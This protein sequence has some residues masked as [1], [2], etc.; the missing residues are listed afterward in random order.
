MNKEKFYIRLS[1]LLGWVI[2]VL[3][4]LKDRPEKNTWIKEAK[5]LKKETDKFLCKKLK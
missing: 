2:M 4:E 5:K 1:T 3:P